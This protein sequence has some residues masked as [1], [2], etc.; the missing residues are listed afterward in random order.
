MLRGIAVQHDLRGEHVDQVTQIALMCE[1][2]GF[3]VF[4]AACDGVVEWEQG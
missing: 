1:F 4:I 3:A 2:A